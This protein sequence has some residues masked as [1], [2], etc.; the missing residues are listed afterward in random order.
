MPG[1]P[2]FPILLIPSIFSQIAKSLRLHM[3]DK[4]QSIPSPFTSM[5]NFL[6]G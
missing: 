1:K 4:K 5:V 6:K 2:Q 3:G